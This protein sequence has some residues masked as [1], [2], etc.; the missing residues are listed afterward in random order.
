MKEAAPVSRSGSDVVA[1]CQRRNRAAVTDRRCRLLLLC[2][3]GGLLF[4]RGLRGGEAR[5]WHTEGGATHVGQADAM[6]EFHRAGVAAANCHSR[7][8]AARSGPSSGQLYSVAGSKSAPFGQCWQATAC[9]RHFGYPV[10]AHETLFGLLPLASR[11]A[12]RLLHQVRGSNR[13]SPSRRINWD[14]ERCS[15]TACGWR[16]R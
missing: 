7:A 9:P 2:L 14:W 11:T 10:A 3:A 13:P 12:Q 8:L 1:L 5:H 6:A 16:G 15:S 4:Q